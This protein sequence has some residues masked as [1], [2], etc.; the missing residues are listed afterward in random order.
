[1]STDKGYGAR[2]IPVDGIWAS[3]VWAL[4]SHPTGKLN[5]IK[6]NEPTPVMPPP[7]KRSRRGGTKNS[8]ARQSSPSKN[9]QRPTA[10]GPGSLASNATNIYGYHEITESNPHWS[11]AL[12]NPLSTSQTFHQALTVTDNLKKEL[13]KLLSRLPRRGAAMYKP[14]SLSEASS[15][16]NARED[17]KKKQGVSRLRGDTVAV[18]AETYRG[19]HPGVCEGD[20]DVAAFWMYTNDYFRDFSVEDATELLAFLKSVDDM[21]EFVLGERGRQGDS[22]ASNHDQPQDPQQNPNVQVQNHRRQRRESQRSSSYLFS[23]YPEEGYNGNG[24]NGLNT[25]LS[26]Q[27]QNSGKVDPVVLSISKAKLQKLH[28]AIGVLKKLVKPKTSQQLHPWT[29]QMLHETRLPNHVV[30]A[31]KEPYFLEPPGSL[32]QENLQSLVKHTE[33]VNEEVNKFIHQSAKHS[34]DKTV[35][36]VATAP[37]DELAAETLALQSELAAVMA[38]NRGRLA[39]PLK[40]LI[41][42]LNEMERKRK[43]REEDEKFAAKYFSSLAQPPQAHALPTAPSLPKP[44][45][46]IQGVHGNQE[47]TFCAICLD[48]FSAP[49]NVILFCDRCD[50]PVHQQCYNVDSIPQHEWL[51]WPCREHEDNLRKEGQTREEI[52]PAFISLEHRSTLPGGSKDAECA[53]CPVKLGAFRKTVDGKHWVHQACALWHPEVILR[54]SNESCVVQGL[55]KIPEERLNYK[56]NL[57]GKDDGAVVR[58]PKLGCAG[59]HHVLCAR[60]CGLYFSK[61]DEGKKIFCAMHG[62][63]EQERDSVMLAKRLAGIVPKMTKVA[64]RRSLEESRK[65]D[66]ITLQALEAELFKLHALRVNFEQLRSLLDLCKKRE[67]L[68]K[69][70]AIALRDCFYLERMR[71]PQTAL[72][73]LDKIKACSSPSR[74]LVEVF[75]MEVPAPS[76]S[77]MIE[78]RPVAPLVMADGSALY[79]LVDERISK[80]GRPRRIAG[81]VER[82]K[83]L[84]VNEAEVL[85]AGLPDG[86]RYVKK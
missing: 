46:D 45:H 54:D 41:K 58:C 85:N 31:V 50:V 80:G 37:Q 17:A 10:A 4:R 65:K 29:Y 69:S 76:T 32:T 22:N 68:A 56:C 84:T 33:K 49:P 43:E 63:A 14:M 12:P 71:N 79:A 44:I 25:Q 62:R 86:L 6:L 78:E 13:Q 70:H 67:K 28:N 21:E 77:G 40:A 18:P 47:D 19:N 73:L 9:S 60:N 23:D 7:K 38:S 2:T 59:A 20:G 74:A 48:G 26:D 16:V 61:G 57:C 55:E 15:Y 82:E 3:S 42:D 8:G 81:N 34:H 72:E 39:G 75:G 53:L 36:V 51:C 11:G 27:T 64:Q 24:Q 1:V 52:R 83:L 66:M 35:A 30:H 5:S